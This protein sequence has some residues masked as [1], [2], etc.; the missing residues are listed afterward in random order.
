MRGWNL[1]HGSWW[2]VQW[3]VDGWVSLGIHVDLRRRYTAVERVPYGP[4]V[5]VHLGV[6]IVSVG[7]NPVYSGELSSSVSVGRGGLRGDAH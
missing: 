7:V 3:Q 4:Y 1:R 5:D 6:M 2:M